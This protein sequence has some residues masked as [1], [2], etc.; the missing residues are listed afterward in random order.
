MLLTEIALVARVPGRA[1]CCRRYSSYKTNKQ[2][3]KQTAC[4]KQPRQLILDDTFRFVLVDETPYLLDWWDA[5][6]RIPVVL[7]RVGVASLH[8][9]T[10][11]PLG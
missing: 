3:N 8:S 1:D 2:T 7:F 10:A 9:E 4:L 6:G 11:M 5:V